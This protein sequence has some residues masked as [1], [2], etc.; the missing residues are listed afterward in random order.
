[1]G[2]ARRQ[3]YSAIIITVWPGKRRAGHTIALNK[4]PLIT[5]TTIYETDIAHNHLYGLD[6]RRLRSQR[7]RRPFGL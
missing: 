3:R 5:Y 1:M 7:L 4:W 6:S 2:Y